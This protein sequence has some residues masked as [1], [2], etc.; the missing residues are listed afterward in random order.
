[1]PE[2]QTTVY[3]IAEDNSRLSLDSSQR[4]QHK[5]LYKLQIKCIDRYTCEPVPAGV[6]SFMNEKSNGVSTTAQ[7]SIS[8]TIFC[9]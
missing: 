4:V 9:R 2:V 3:I 6:V 8:G 7:Q 5:T 1:M